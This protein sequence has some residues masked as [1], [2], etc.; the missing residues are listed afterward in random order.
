M[1]SERSGAPWPVVVTLGVGAAAGALASLWLWRKVDAL[2]RELEHSRRVKGDYGIQKTA[3][4]TPGGPEMP[5]IVGRG[6]ADVEEAGV[7][8]FGQGDDMDSAAFALQMLQQKNEL[9]GLLQEVSCSVGEWEAQHKTLS[10]SIARRPG[11]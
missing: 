10:E 7:D 5:Q 2:E 1:G 4:I 3:V 9:L 11:S 6:G 8:G